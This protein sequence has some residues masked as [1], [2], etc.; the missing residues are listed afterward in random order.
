MQI[1]LGIFL[2]FHGWVHMVYAGQSAQ[3][4]QFRPG[5]T[6][7]N[8]A[9]AFSRLLGDEMTRRLAVGALVL[10]ALSFIGG[11]LGVFFRQAWWRPVAA[12]AAIASAGLYLLMWNGKFEALDAQGAVGILLNLAVL[13]VAFIWKAPLP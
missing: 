11:G 12:A 8:G 9:W 6:W 3:L 7:P 13:A 4:F 2:V 5:F 1:V 10:I